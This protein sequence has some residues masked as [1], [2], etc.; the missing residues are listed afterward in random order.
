MTSDQLQ[1]D[2]ES[3]DG[4]DFVADLFDQAVRNRLID[5]QDSERTVCFRVERITDVSNVDAPSCKT[6]AYRADNT[7]AIVVQKERRVP[8]GFEIKFIEFTS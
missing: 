2:I 5:S 6:D 3:R 7:G 1:L 8:Y 4:L